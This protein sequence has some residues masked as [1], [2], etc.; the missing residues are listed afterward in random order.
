MFALPFKRKPA[1]VIAS[2]FSSLLT[3]TDPHSIIPENSLIG[4]IAGNG[5]FPVLFC[6]SARRFGY[7]VFVV[8]LEGEVDESVRAVADRMEMVKV[9]EFGRLCSLFTDAGVRYAAMA[10]GV[11]RVNLFGGVK[12]DARG[13]M[14]LLRLRSAKDDV[15][16]R[17][18]AG[19]LAHDGITVVSSS[20]F[21]SEF[22]IPEGVLTKSRPSKD[23]EEDIRVGRAALT[24]MSSQDIGQL[25]VVKEGVVVAVEAVEGSDAAIR[26]GGAL[27]G[28]GT[29]VVKFPKATQDLRFDLPTVGCRTIEAMSEVGSRVLAV[30]AGRCLMLDRDEMLALANSKKIVVIGV[31]PA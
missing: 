29:V 27:G 10:G 25:V 4:L 24:A 3:T 20:L 1:P 23:E 30:E 5:R 9:G 21:M 22:L 28:P 19:E 14:L 31:G 18:V 8:G 6:E 17:G 11:K 2:A 16:M 7:R 12:L 13:A 15:I 26:R